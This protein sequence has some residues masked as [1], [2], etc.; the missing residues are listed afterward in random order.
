MRYEKNRKKVR[1]MTDIENRPK[2]TITN[3]EYEEIDIQYT[4][5]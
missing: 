5:E 3:I 1:I 2:N 4:Q